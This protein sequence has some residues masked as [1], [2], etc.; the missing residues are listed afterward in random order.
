MFTFTSK[1]EAPPVAPFLADASFFF[2]SPTR[3]LLAR[4]ARE[5][6]RELGSGAGLAD[7]VA[8]RLAWHSRDGIERPL[9]VGALP[10][11]EAAPAR[12]FVLETYQSVGPS[13]PIEPA[14]PSPLAGGPPR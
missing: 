7:H 9:V 5:T 4:G 12:L 2:A 14:A 6:I 10:F 13:G 1:S 3:T 11:D 8:A